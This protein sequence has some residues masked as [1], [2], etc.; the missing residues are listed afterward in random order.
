MRDFVRSFVA[1]MVMLVPWGV[2]FSSPPAWVYR[3][4]ARSPRE[5]FTHGFAARGDDDDFAFH[6]LS[7]SHSLGNSAFVSTTDDYYIALEFAQDVMRQRQ[8][9]EMYVYRIR[10]TDDFY[11]A[12]ATIRAHRRDIDAAGRAS[13]LGAYVR[14]L[15]QELPGYE[16]E[17]EWFVHHHIP[18]QI[19]NW[20]RRLTPSETPLPRTDHERPPLYLSEGA[21]VNNDSHYVHAN[22][23]GNPEPYPMTVPD[24]DPLA[25]SPSECSSDGECPNDTVAARIGNDW[26]H[27]DDL[28]ECD[29]RAKR[30][31]GTSQGEC[32][33]LFNKTRMGRAASSAVS[34]W[35]LFSS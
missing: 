21:I 6:F 22:T 12:I 20:G 28:P 34:G 29:R 18:S 17:R 8:L 19:I 23:L 32:V 7:I 13:A 5:I 26:A 2:A 27:A 9:G 31:V 24:G 11:N 30:P 1:V 16:W 15:D 25:S 4:D 3:V 14:R 35:L 10:A 33:R